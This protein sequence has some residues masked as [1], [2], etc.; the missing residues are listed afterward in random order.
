MLNVLFLPLICFYL[1]KNAIELDRHSKTCELI[2][3]TPVSKQAYLFPKWCVNVFILV[4]VL[5]VMLVSAVVVQL[6]YGE[7]YHIDLWA[8]LWPQLVYV[9]PLLFAIASIALM[10]ESIKW[11]RG[12]LGNLAY[13]FLWLGS[14]TYTFFNV[15]GIGSLMKSLD[16]EVAARFPANNKG[17][18]IGIT[19]TDEASPIKTFVWQGVEP[20]FADLWGALPFMMISLISL[21]IAYL[22]FDRFSQSTITKSKQASWLNRKLLSKISPLLDS[23]FT[24]LTKHFAFTQL[25]YL[26]IKLLTKGLSSYWFIGLLV[27]NIMQLTVD[28]PLLTS[29]ILPLSWL[30]CMLV[31]S[32]LG[33]FEKQSGTQEII[34]YS[35]QSSIYQ[36]LACFVGAWTLLVIASLGSVIRFTF[37]FEWLLLLQILIATVFTVAL[38]YICGTVTGTRR[39]FEGLYPLLWYIGLIQSMLYVDFFWRKQSVKLASRNAVLL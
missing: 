9:I 17:S 23:C 30:W 26:E 16:T 2:A 10:F 25:M 39:M 34:K 37:T 6:Y 24:A 27:L 28:K 15:S 22:C 21:F 19:A 20:S 12:G 1:I 29:L 13:F 4:S 7:S 31:I 5:P 32:Q 18:N 33:Q 38:A 36:T 3:A 8:L 11:L 35:Q 14:I